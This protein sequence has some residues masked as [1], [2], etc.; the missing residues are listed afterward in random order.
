[1]FRLLQSNHHQAEYQKYKKEIILHIV[2]GRDLGLTGLLYIRLYEVSVYV[3]CLLFV[4]TY[5]NVVYS[6]WF[7]DTWFWP[8]FYPKVRFPKLVFLATCLS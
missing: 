6:S 8:N 7:I 5:H 2:Y 3:A 1:M 4:Q